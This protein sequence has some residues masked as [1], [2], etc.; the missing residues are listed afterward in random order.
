M[1]LSV[2]L[3]SIIIAHAVSATPHLYRLM[4]STKVSRGYLPDTLEARERQVEKFIA[5]RNADGV[6]LNAALKAKITASYG[7]RSLLAPLFRIYGKLAAC[8]FRKQRAPAHIVKS[9]ESILKTFRKNMISI[10]KPLLEAYKVLPFWTS[11]IDNK[12][13]IIV[14]HVFKDIEDVIDSFSALVKACDFKGIRKARDSCFK[15]FVTGLIDLFVYREPSRDQSAEETITDMATRIVIDE[16]LYDLAHWSFRFASK[17][18]KLE[19]QLYTEPALAT[20][21]RNLAALL[22]SF[23]LGNHVYFDYSARAIGYNFDWHMGTFPDD[24]VMLL[25]IEDRLRYAISQRSLF[26]KEINDWVDFSE[27]CLEKMIKRQV[28]SD[29][30]ERAAH[31]KAVAVKVEKSERVE[32]ALR[33][34]F[35]ARAKRYLG[36]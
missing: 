19:L 11:E 18:A 27:A 26:H 13:K 4:V 1:I 21:T 3:I 23:I 22:S 12:S 17:Q 29:I 6:L 33:K 31:F 8:Y 20:K 16:A 35:V 2:L 28:P 7:L 5:T 14:S 36:L 15:P 30:D 34:A 10:Y 24:E 32:L 25:T 9:L